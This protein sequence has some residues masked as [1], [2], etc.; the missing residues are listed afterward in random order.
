MKRKTLILL[1]GIA[2]LSTLQNTEYATDFNSKS[3]L[4]PINSIYTEKIK[5]VRMTVL[6]GIPK[7]LA[8]TTQI[9]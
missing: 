9:S 5:L 2:I 7:F 3:N 6:I 8:G 4:N 1:V